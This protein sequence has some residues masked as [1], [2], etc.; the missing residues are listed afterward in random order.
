MALN[1]ALHTS[2]QVVENSFTVT[3]AGTVL[4]DVVERLSGMKYVVAEAI[5][6]YGSGGTSA[7]AYLQ[8]SVDDGVTWI[9]IASFAFTTSTASK[10]SSLSSTVA[11]TAATAPTD[12]SLTDNTVVNGLLGSQLRW[13]VISVGTYAATTLKCNYVAKG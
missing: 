3:A 13:K 4:S 9:D 10:V 6:T 12:G 8:T 1:G 7:K 2:G 5:F 11:L